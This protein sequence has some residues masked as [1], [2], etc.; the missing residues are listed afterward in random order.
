MKNLPCSGR[1]PRHPEKGIIYTQTK[2][3]CFTLLLIRKFNT[4][5]VGVDVLGDP[6][7]TNFGREIAFSADLCY[8]WF[9][10]WGLAPAAMKDFV[11]GNG[12][13]KAPPY[14]GHGLCPMH[15]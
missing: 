1:R 6:Q 2:N 5:F 8:N 11:L 14:K 13:T 7:W 10:E 4:I 12:G 15:L 3:A 9:V